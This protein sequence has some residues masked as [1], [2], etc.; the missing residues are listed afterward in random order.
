MGHT[1]PANYIVRDVKIY[2]SKYLW[3]DNPFPLVDIANK[4]SLNHTIKENLLKVHGLR[5]PIIAGAC[6]QGMRGLKEEN[7]ICNRQ[8]CSFCMK[9]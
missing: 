1:V 9:T 3:A 5:V 7:Y 4:S 6:P 8:F 2:N